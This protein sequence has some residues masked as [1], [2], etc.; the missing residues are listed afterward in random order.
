MASH[1]ILLK[2][3]M[4]YWRSVITSHNAGQDIMYILAV[5]LFDCWP[6]LLHVMTSF[7]KNNGGYFRAMKQVQT[8]SYGRVPQYNQCT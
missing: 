1:I 6:V 4:L 3:V 7:K 8:N 5:T 2:L